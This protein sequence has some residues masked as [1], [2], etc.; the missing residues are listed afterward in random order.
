MLNQIITDEKLGKVI[1]GYIKIYKILSAILLA[2]SI[3]TSLIEKDI[4]SFLTVLFVLSVGLVLAL[5]SIAIQWYIYELTNIS[6]KEKEYKLL[7]WSIIIYGLINFVIASQS[8]DITVITVIIALLLSFVFGTI[9]WF[10]T[11]LIAFLFINLCLWFDKIIKKDYL[12]FQFKVSD[13]SD[14]AIIAIL[15]SIFLSLGTYVFLDQ[16]FEFQLSLWQTIYVAIF[17]LTI[18]SLFGI[19]SKAGLQA[20]AAF[21][22]IYGLIV[23]LKVVEKPLWWVFLFAIP[24]VNIVIQ[25]WIT[26]LLSLK[27]GKDEGFTAGLIILP[28]IFY[29]ILAFGPS[30]YKAGNQ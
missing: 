13:N 3:I 23:L 9:G 7:I 8:I 10:I 18:L 6:F 11:W 27:F 4:S 25:I 5:I 24:G 26:N 2:L 20:W 19:Y 30:Q 22:P 29:P 15:A 21:V 1:N 17:W 12:V 16:I 14:E 28:F